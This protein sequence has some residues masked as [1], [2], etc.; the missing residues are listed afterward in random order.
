MRPTTRT[1]ESV[2]QPMRRPGHLTSDVRLLRDVA[3]GVRLL[4][5]SPSFTIITLIVFAIGIGAATA[6]V[7]VADTLFLRPLAVAHADRVMTVWQYNREGG[8]RGQDVAPGNAI[9]WMARARSFD[10]TAVAESLAFNLNFAGREP[11][12][13][14]A[15][16]V[17][18][19]FFTVLGVNALHG[20]TFLPEEYQRG[21]A[22]VV[23]LSHA[24]WTFRFGGDPLVVGRTVRLEASEPF[25]VVGVMP[26]GLELRLFHDSSGAR[27]PET[28]IWMP[29][30]GFEAAE[31]SARGGGF[32]N[33]LGRLRPGVS[34]DQAQAEFDVI[35]A[36]LARDYPATNAKVGAEVVPLRSHLAG[37][38]RDVLPLLAGAA[39]ILLIIACANVAN[40]LMA[41]GAARG[42]EFAVRQALGASRPQLVR[43]MLVE[44]L[45]LA[46]AGGVLGLVMARWTLDVFERLRPRD[47]GLLDSVPID[48]RAAAIACAV[49]VIAAILA[50]LTPSLQLSR[51]AAANALRERRQTSSR[52]TRMVLVVVEVAAALLLAVGAGLLVR[53]F[54]L[55]QRV[56]P[57]F[58]HKHVSVLQLF[59][60]SRIQAIPTRIVFFDQLLDRV[61]ALP[62][63]VAAGAVSSLPFGEARVIVRG[64]LAIPDRPSAPGDD[65]LAYMSAVTGDYFKTM[66]VPLVAGRLF[67]ATDTA[68][69]RQVVLVSRSAAQQF[70]RGADPLRSKVRFRFSGKTFDAEVVGVVGDVRHETLERPAA[71]EVFVPYAQIGFHTLTFVVQTTPGSPASLPAL[72]EQVWSL[73]PLQP[74]YHTATLD[75][76]IA[77]TLAG[78]RFSLFVLGGCALAALLLSTAGIYGVMSFTTSQRTREF[79]VR[80]ALGAVHRDILALV[81]REGLALAA[82]GLG[83]GIIGALLIARAWRTLLFGV[84]ASDPLT[85]VIVSLMFLLVAAAASY[86]P[87]KRAMRVDPVR[88]LRFE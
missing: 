66:D 83:I 73:D 28:A 54:M 64:P 76:L 87:A 37:S 32:W 3:F 80:M 33:V 44:T 60:S 42:Q 36:Q 49:T 75:G 67:N 82:A 10:S 84:T 27:R 85:F 78:R 68:D 38:M 4:V 48:V 86:L 9:D 12:Y 25:T 6:I 2:P 88:A 46:L 17:S 71:A 59:V 56:D 31:K 16:R 55:V 13:L 79:G 41:H 52:K 63:V 15:A 7:S 81:L 26:A 30:Q 14:T 72:K 20:R 24:T 74:I 11:D 35:S 40:L 69:S 47:I 29:K 22:R 65:A 58:D 77:K 51:P 50:G 70:W 21:G 23:M 45:L 18:D 5:K 19:R 62:G 53:S 43:Q 1:L 39:A 61:R 57:G 34:V 8:L